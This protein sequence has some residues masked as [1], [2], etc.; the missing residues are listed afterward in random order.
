IYSGIQCPQGLSYKPASVVKGNDLYLGYSAVFQCFFR[1]SGGRITLA[2]SAAAFILAV[3]LASVTP[4]NPL[5]RAHAARS[6]TL[7]Q[8]NAPVEATPPEFAPPPPPLASS[9][10]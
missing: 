5:E 10:E 1:K 4:S 6:A 2:M 9:A 3:L 8:W 7:L